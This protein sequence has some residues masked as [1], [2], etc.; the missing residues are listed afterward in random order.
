MGAG[1]AHLA[2]LRSLARAPLPG[3][4]VTLVNP[5]AR[6]HYSGMVPGYLQGTYAEAELAIDL[7]PLCAAAQAELWPGAAERVDVAARR[8]VV[9]RDVL[10]FDLLSLDVGSAPAGI[11]APG[12]REYA[13]CVRPLRE[14]LSLRDV[15]D[16]GARDVARK[17]APV[18]VFVVGGGAGAVEVALALHRRIASGGRH[19]AVSIVERGEAI[20]ADFAPPARERLERVLARRGIAVLLGRRVTA[21]KAGAVVLDPGTRRKSDL[22][23]WIAGAAPPPLLARS[24]L[25]TRDGYLLVDDTLRAAGGAPVWGA[26]DCVTLVGHPGLPKAGVFAVR[27]GPVLA[28]NLRAALLGGTPRRYEPQTSVLSLLNTADGRAFYRWRGLSGYTRWAWLL[29]DAIDRRWVRQYQ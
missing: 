18:R 25:P 11:D 27:Q 3:V 14:A 2:V 8:V 4:R 6:Y 16:G 24:D 15:V 7:P 22:T 10:D 5:D 17:E 29:K 9:G 21:V 20:V 12:A 23:V 26:G 1:H 19:P 13:R 28:H